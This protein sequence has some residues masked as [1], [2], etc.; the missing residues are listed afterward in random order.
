MNNLILDNEKAA[1]AAFFI[2][3]FEMNF[4]KKIR[5]II[6]KFIYEY[7]KNLVKPRPI[8]HFIYLSLP[9]AQAV[10]KF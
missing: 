7:N 3:N 8:F 1:I 10:I 9:H 6:S 5:L 2:Y 4:F